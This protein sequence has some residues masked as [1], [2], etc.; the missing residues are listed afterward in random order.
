MRILITNDDGI[1][2]S[3]IDALV[4]VAV[5]HGHEVVVSAPHVEQSAVSMHL[6]LATPLVIHASS[7]W[8]GVT[9]FAVKGTP[10]DCV[11]LAK[12]LTDNEHFDF[13]LSGINDGE[14]AGSAVY[15]SGTVSAAREAAMH[16]I[17]AMAVSICKGSNQEMLDSLAERAINLMEHCP[18]RKWPR[19]GVL[20]LN[21]PAVK[22]SELKETVV[23]PLSSAY[24]TD[25][26]ERRRNPHGTTYFWM[27]DGLPM[28]EPEEK[29]DYAYLLKG[30]PTLTLLSVYSDCNEAIAGILGRE[31]D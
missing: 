24:Y 25:T 19:M 28:E 3:G 16:Y 12:Q 17:P 5:A 22:P 20:S 30:H 10:T 15:Y 26:Y 11:R 6:T 21:A 23:C 18:V 31:F 13:C 14:N 29:S 8:K 1:Q 9:A 2:S 7:R 27:N 4:R